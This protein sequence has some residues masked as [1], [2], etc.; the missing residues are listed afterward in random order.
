MKKL[1][2]SGAEQLGVSIMRSNRAAE[3]LRAEAVIAAQT[4]QHDPDLV[5][6]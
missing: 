4:F 2:K 3:L 6:G 5:L 1:V